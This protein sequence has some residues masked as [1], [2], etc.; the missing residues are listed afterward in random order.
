M[1][2]PLGETREALLAR[3]RAA[4]RHGTA[5]VPDPP[6]VADAL[7]RLVPAECDLVD[8]FVRHA[9]KCGMQ[10]R[11]VSETELPLRVLEVLAHVGAKR[12]SITQP[13][14]APV[15][16]EAGL[17]AVDGAALSYDAQFDLDASVTGVDAAVA[18]TGSLVC[19]SGAGRKRGLSLIP[20]VHVAVVRAADVVADLLDLW[21]RLRSVDGLMPAGVALI[22]GPSKTADIEG[23]LVTGVHGPEQ[24]FVLVVN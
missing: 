11:I 16:R 10:V 22:T 6:R 12:V 3:V 13:D 8:T 2:E 19:T 4:L 20:P 5:V 15:L 7:A 9:T 21:P 1:N 24:V 17:E 14:L 23:I 18:E